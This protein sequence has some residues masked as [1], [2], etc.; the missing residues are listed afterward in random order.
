MTK[1]HVL[2]LGGNFA[3]IGAAQ[4]ILEHAPDSVTM[5]V[6]D[7]KPYWRIDH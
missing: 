2:V 3:G 7:R 1:P 6:I 4:K 5:T